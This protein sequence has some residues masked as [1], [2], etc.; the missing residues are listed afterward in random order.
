MGNNSDGL[1]HTLTHTGKSPGGNGGLNSTLD[2]ILL[3][4]KGPKT[5]G[6]QGI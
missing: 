6:A 1:T 3:D 5:V 2:L 4:Q